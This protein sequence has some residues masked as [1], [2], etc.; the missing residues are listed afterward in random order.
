MSEIFVGFGSNLGDRS[1]T[2]RHAVTTLDAMPGV[3]LRDCSGMR[4]TEPV[5]GPPQPHFVNAVARFDAAIPPDALLRVLQEIEHAHGR[6]RGVAN[7]PRTLDLDLLLYG[8]HR[9]AEE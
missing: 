6:R 1:R 7:G 3:R 2:L 5:G 9:L 4:E 8:H